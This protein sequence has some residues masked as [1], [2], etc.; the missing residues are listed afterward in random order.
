MDQYR[1]YVSGHDLSKRMPLWIKPNRKISNNDVM[2]FMRDHLEG[3]EF[4]MRKDI[5]A[6]LFW[7]SLPLASAYMESHRRSKCPFIL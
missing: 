2:N 7:F 6:G 1:N 3:T 4:D 5:G